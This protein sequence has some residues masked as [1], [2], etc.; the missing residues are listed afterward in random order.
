MLQADKNILGIKPAA[1]PNQG[2]KHPNRGEKKRN[3]G[4]NPIKT[5]NNFIVILEKQKRSHVI[6]KRIT[7]MTILCLD[8][9]IKRSK[10]SFIKDE[11]KKRLFFSYV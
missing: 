9:D 5:L 8:V 7:L 2:N 11:G 1:K 3:K 6:K 4:S 10:F